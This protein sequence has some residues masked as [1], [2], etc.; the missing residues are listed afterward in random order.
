MKILI[1]GLNYEPE[2][3]GIAVYT[4]GLA[5]NLVERGHEVRVIAAKP[6]YPAW[7]LMDGHSPFSFE[8]RDGKRCSRDPCPALH[9]GQTN[10]CQ[11]LNPLCEL[12]LDQLFFRPFGQASAGV[13][14][15]SSLLRRH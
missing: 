8:S 12:C 11:T 5:E 3:V 6:Y 9:S 1:L 7:K 10:L 4:T 2:K 14:I 15:W 13:R